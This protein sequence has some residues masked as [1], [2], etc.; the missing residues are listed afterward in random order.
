MSIDFRNF[1]IDKVITHEIFQK[2]IDKKS[3]P[4]Y[5]TELIEF[6]TKAKEEL[7]KRIISAIGQNK[8]SLEMDIIEKS[9]DSVYSMVSAFMNEEDSND[10]SFISVSKLI[11]KKLSDSQQRRTIPGGVVVIFTGTIDNDDKLCMG[12]IKAEKHSGFHLRTLD[13][14]SLMEYISNL[15]LT[16]AQKLYKVAML[17]KD[18]SFNENNSNDIHAFI[19]DSNND[20]N[21]IKS[22]ADYFRVGFMGCEFQDTSSNST[23]NFYLTSRDFF[24]KHSSSKGTKMLEKLDDLL[25]YVKNPMNNTICIGDFNEYLTSPEEKDDYMKYMLEHNVPPTIHKDL[26]KIETMIN[27]RTIRFENNISL[28]L[29]MENY[30]ENISLEEETRDG[31]Y[32]TVIKI[33]G[34]IRSAR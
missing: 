24:T 4:Y 11:T 15:L 10:Q 27:K 17:I 7:N 12:I 8:F 23:K 34:D 2:E 13:G 26:S 20:V 5:N 21:K 33:K 30:D 22:T 14:K 16:P 28:S 31:E 1:K 19:Y 6:D 32:Y 25:T 18:E 9:E 3:E 29:P